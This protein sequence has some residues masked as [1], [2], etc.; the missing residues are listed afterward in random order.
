M[1]TAASC[2]NDKLTVDNPVNTGDEI[3]FGSSLPES[4]I[5]TRVTY[6]EPD[7]EN[8]EFPVYWE[9]GDE[10]V[11]YCPQSAGSQLAHYTVGVSNSTSTVAESITRVGDGA[12]QWGSEDLHKFYGFYPAKYVLGTET[13]GAFNMN[14]PVNQT[15]LNFTQDSNGNWKSDVNTDYAIMYAYR[16]QKKSNTPEGTDIDLHFTPLSTILEIIVQGPAEANTTLTLTNIN[17]RTLDG[18]PIVGDFIAQVVPGS[19]T[20]ESSVGNVIFSS[21]KAGKVDNNLSIPCSWKEGEETKFVTLTTGQK[22][23]LKA[24]LIPVLPEGVEALDSKNVLISVSTT[25]GTAQ[26]TLVNSNGESFQILPNKVN[27][28]TLPALKTNFETAYWINSLDPDIYLT[29]LSI[30]GSKMTTETKVNNAPLEYQSTTIEQQYRDGVRAFILQCYRNSDGSLTVARINQPLSNILNEISAYLQ[31]ATNKGKREFAFVLITYQATN[32]SGTGAQW[33]QSLQTTIN[34]MGDNVI[35]KQ[36]ITPTS[37]IRDVAG[38]IIIKCNYND[39]SMIQGVGSAPMLYT[40]WQGAYVEGG[41]DMPWGDPNS[42]PKLKWLYEEVTHVSRPGYCNG[43]DHEETY[44]NKVAYLTMVFNESIDEYK[45]GTLN[46][47][48]M[49]DLGGNYIYCTKTGNHIFHNE[50]N[51]VVSLTKDINQVAIEL[52]QGRTEN[53]GLGLV[54]MNYANRQEDTGAAYKSDLL[55]QTIIDNNFKFALRKKETGTTNYNADYS[56]GG[57]AIE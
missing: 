13:T 12:L 41:I 8:R 16:G 53:A 46:T 55:L 1:L 5:E 20:E 30:P 43:A 37:T 10:I 7:M 52:L 42:T 26:K 28:V 14:V 9:N 40:M 33:V 50:V 2:V 23:Y 6:G 32:G 31:E 29:E 15:A 27:R 54:F 39:P 22:L 25:K 34:A 4:G 51:D 47:W 56:D 57:F 19:D 49:S 38:K 3:T 44:E 45:L 48:F 21:D 36:E 11:I 18:T 35:Y 17:V 24:F